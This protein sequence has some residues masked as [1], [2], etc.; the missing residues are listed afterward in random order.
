V[1]AMRVSLPTQ[2]NSDVGSYAVIGIFVVMVVGILGLF[3]RG[4]RSLAT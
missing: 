2:V 3:F 4:V 1:Q